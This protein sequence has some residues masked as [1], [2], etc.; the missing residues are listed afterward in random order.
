MPVQHTSRDTK[1]YYSTPMGEIQL[2]S[3]T[4]PSGMK[5]KYRYVPHR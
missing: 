2:E 4:I 3:V 1:G 5:V